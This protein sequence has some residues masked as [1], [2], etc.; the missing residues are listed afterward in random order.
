[1]GEVKA[2]TGK[3]CST[4]TLSTKEVANTA[5]YTPARWIIWTVM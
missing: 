3:E 4:R 2:S 1:M 5:E